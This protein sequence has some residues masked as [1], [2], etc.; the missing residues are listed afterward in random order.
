MDHRRYS[1]HH[2]Q[3][4]KLWLS[5]LFSSLLSSLSS[6]LSSLQLARL[7]KK[8]KD[9]LYNLVMPRFCSSL[10]LSAVSV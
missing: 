2:H 9:L 10:Q 5:F 6:S 4:L 7:L 1:E 8:D 3:I